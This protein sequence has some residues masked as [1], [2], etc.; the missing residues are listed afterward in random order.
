MMICQ[1]FSC[2]SAPNSLSAHLSLLSATLAEVTF[3]CT[4]RK[5]S[6]SE[7]NSLRFYFWLPSLH[8]DTMKSDSCMIH[9]FSDRGVCWWA[10]RRTSWNTN[11]TEF[12]PGKIKPHL[13]C[14]E[15]VLMFV[16]MNKCGYKTD[17]TRF[18]QSESDTISRCYTVYY[19]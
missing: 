6:E 7:S 1:H 12:I 19:L 3:C 10:V 4:R 15:S 8:R 5:S 9:G 13:C 17:Y 2:L 14:W 16:L 11:S 18:L